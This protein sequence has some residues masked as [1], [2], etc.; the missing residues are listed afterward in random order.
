M[1]CSKHLPC[2]NSNFQNSTNHRLLLFSSCIWDILAQRGNT[3]DDPRQPISTGSA[4]TTLPCSS[5]A[6]VVSEQVVG[7]HRLSP[8]AEWQAFPYVISC[9]LAS[10]A[11]GDVSS[12]QFHKRTLGLGD[13]T[14][15]VQGHPAI[16][17]QAGDFVSWMK[18]VK[19]MGCLLLETT[20]Q[21]DQWAHNFRTRVWFCES[22][23]EEARFLAWWTEPHTWILSFPNN[24]CLCP[25]SN[26]GG[27]MCPHL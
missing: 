27:W 24:P 9:A 15:L 8:N 5:L 26:K 7:K 21:V 14:W 25:L 16:R 20:S 11:K 12:P 22:L 17:G 2:S 4:L 23:C 19:A 6:G 13:V 10:N 18:R 1:H 3:A